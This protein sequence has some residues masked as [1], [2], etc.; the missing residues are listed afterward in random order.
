MQRPIFKDFANLWTAVCLS[1]RVRRNRPLSLTIA[2][3]RLVLFRGEDGS[4]H[5]LVDRCP[6]RGVALSLGSVKDGVITC[7]F[8]GWQFNASGRCLHVPWNPDA[9][10]DLLSAMGLTVQEA[11]GIIWLYTGKEPKADLKEPAILLRSDVR[12]TAQSFLW[13]VHWTRVMENMLDAPHLPFVHAKTIGKHL[14]S[15]SASNMEMVWTPTGYGAD[16][17]TLRPGEPPKTNLRFHF[18]NAMEMVIDPRGK[19]FRL[20]AVCTPARPGETQLTIYTLRSFAKARIL[21]GLFARMNARIA[22]EDKAIV[23]SSQPPEVPPANEEQSVASD[24]PTL[25]FRKIWFSQIRRSVAA[26]ISER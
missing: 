8:H 5:A 9:K 4:P 20:L 17:T 21:D 7:P 19:I 16:I 26:Y 11:G 10:L 3:E 18:P 25:A 24:A 14:Q 23:E 6:H 2:G 15:R 22:A 1:D 12:V 13:Q